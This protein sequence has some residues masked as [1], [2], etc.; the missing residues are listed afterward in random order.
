M[1]NTKDRKRWLNS[2]LLSKDPKIKRVAL[3][4]ELERYEA[5]LKK[6]LAKRGDAFVHGGDGWHDN[7]AFE[8]LEA[9]YDFL[10]SRVRQIKNELL[11]LRTKK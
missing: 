4:E 5:R 1:T 11:E 7:P 6:C 8:A 9:E 3:E 10:K 2:E